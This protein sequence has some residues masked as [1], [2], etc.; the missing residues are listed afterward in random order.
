MEDFSPRELK[1]RHAILSGVPGD[2]SISILMTPF[3]WNQEIV[4]TSIRLDAIDLPSNMLR[5]LAGKLFEFP[6]SPNDGYIDGSIHLKN[7]HHPV[8]VTSL[9]FSR[10]RDGQLTLIVRGVYVFD[11]E[12]LDDLGKS[13]FTMAVTVSSCAV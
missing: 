3:L 5:D 4:D 6:T 10:S 9:S 13:P 11:F 12:G 7:A 2:V 1:A 8:D